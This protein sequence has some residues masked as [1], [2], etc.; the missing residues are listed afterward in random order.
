MKQLLLI[1]LSGLPL[2]REKSGKFK[3]RE[4]SGNFWIGQGNLKFCVKVREKSGKNLYLCHHRDIGQSVLQYRISQQKF[5][6]RLRR[7]C[8]PIYCIYTAPLDTHRPHR[9][10]AWNVLYL[11]YILMKSAYKSLYFQEGYAYIFTKSCWK[12]WCKCTLD[13]TNL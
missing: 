9:F 4:K 7:A 13:Y 1:R 11:P 10:A 2:V 6:T 12:P 3:V 5:F 8:F